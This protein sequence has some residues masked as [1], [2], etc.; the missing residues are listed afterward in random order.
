MRLYYRLTDTQDPEERLE[1]AALWK[2]M[3][4]VFEDEITLLPFDA[5]TPQDGY[6]FGRGKRIE[7]VRQPHLLIQ[8]SMPYWRDQAFLSN[9]R[10]M[11]KL[12]TWADAMAE[13]DR[14][15]KAGLGVFLKATDTKKMAVR[16][17]VGSDMR[18][19]T[20]GWAYSFIDRP[21]CIMVQELVDMKYERRFVVID[22]EIITQSPVA[23]H[24]TPL[25]TEVLSMHYPTP[26]HRGPAIRSSELT[27]QMTDFVERVAAEMV[28][29]HA[30]IDVALINGKIGVIEFNAARI[31][32]FG[33]YA[34]DPYAIARAVKV[35]LAKTIE[36]EA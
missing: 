2:A 22:R 13:V 30:I 9:S 21:P 11:F 28:P 20:E 12:M 29:D 32:Q 36:A 3:H 18:E 24:L 17:P 1:D 35:L 25:N 10:R 19:L 16:L 4:D 14:L 27:L 34:C 23:V 6:F 31:G 15:H 33:L 7:Y 26:T 5:A 8:D